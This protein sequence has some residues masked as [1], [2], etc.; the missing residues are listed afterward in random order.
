MSRRIK[1]DVEILS[2]YIAAQSLTH[3]I[4]S[5]DAG[6]VSISIQGIQNFALYYVDCESYP[7]TSV[8]ISTEDSNCEAA[9]LSVTDLHEHRS[10]LGDVLQSLCKALDVAPPALE[11]SAADASGSAENSHS[12]TF[13]E[14][15]AASDIETD[16]GNT[17]EDSSVCQD[18][19]DEIEATVKVY[20]KIT[21]WKAVEENA[22]IPDF[23]K[24][25]S[26]TD[27]KDGAK[28]A[29]G[30][31]ASGTIE[32]KAA[33]R[34]QMFNPQEAFIQLSGELKK[35]VQGD[36]P[37]LEV[38]AI[39]D[40]VY[41][42]DVNITSVS[43][44]SPLADDLTAL[45]RRTGNRSIHLRLTFKRGLHPF[46]PVAVQVVWPRFKGPLAGALSS[47][48]SLQVKAWDPTRGTFQVLEG[49]VHFLELVGRV[50][51][52]V[53]VAAIL[54]GRPAYRPEEH[55]LLRLEALT[56]LRPA[57]ALDFADMYQV[58]GYSDAE[59]KARVEALQ[60][61]K[62]LKTKESTVTEAAQPRAWATGVGFGSGRHTQEWDAAAA[63]A[64]A[65][66]TQAARDNE[67]HAVTASIHELL[68]APLQQPACGGGSGVEHAT[69]DC[70]A[71]ESCLI[72]FLSS[73]LCTASFSNMTSRSTFYAS[74]LQIVCQLSS[75]LMASACNRQHRLPGLPGSIKSLAVVLAA[76]RRQ[77][78]QFL[79][80]C[81]SAS[82]DSGTATSSDPHPIFSIHSA[83]STANQPENEERSSVYLANLIA[84]ATTA[85][86]DLAAS[87]S[88]CQSDT[89]KEGHVQLA[90][91]LSC[92]AAPASSTSAAASTR[93]QHKARE[94]ADS[95]E[96]A[97]AKYCDRMKLLQMD[98]WNGLSAGHLYEKSAAK[99]SA[100]PRSRIHRVAKE[101]ASLVADLPLSFSSSV[102]VRVDEQKATLWRALI[103]GPEDTPYSCGCFI[104]DMYFPPTYPG[105]PPQVLL[106]TTGG[107]RVRFNPNLYDSGKVCLSLLGTWAG[108][109]GETWDSSVSTM[110][111]V[112]V[113]IQSL[114]LVP[115]PFFNEP[116]YETTMHTPKGQQDSANYSANI[117]A[118]TMQ[119]AIEEQLH[120]PAP[121]FAEV[122]RDH[123]RLRKEVVV[124]TCKAFI[125]TVKKSDNRKLAAGMEA[126]LK[127]IERLLSALT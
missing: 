25:N 41:K 32:E 34:L 61:T 96:T 51:E 30:V 16:E 125:D 2:K 29:I 66:A 88:V 95:P 84:A 7:A 86:A 115:D 118:S 90:P 19:L 55:L 63:A 52:D 20:Q 4:A 97:S 114:I 89:S 53:S 31:T 111:Q 50:D 38:D 124:K 22:S 48:P 121:E 123:F 15:D 60:Q 71:F 42:W 98:T 85:V 47:H 37:W 44:T 67:L 106:R 101:V 6:S 24:G 40:D 3:R 102:F 65:D 11:P 39:D 72:D 54:E 120:R 49:L 87:Q 99:E 64:T 23:I 27:T 73:Q 45:E 70:L 103:T 1:E 69:L 119:Y 110:L 58:Q 107:G 104:F 108:A 122:I 91:P 80:V 12:G 26:G 94:D 82:A 116:G 59:H 57:C 56:G 36:I 5:Q 9:A 17:D 113:S 35:G 100:H 76:L 127:N 112:L 28:G 10:T 62:R 8:L 77:G 74:L 79:R 78:D 93:R 126:R 81:S 105:A 46:Y 43:P 117:M 21:R 109:K 14:R 83:G 13:G 92:A 75:Q 18:D 68:V 33:A